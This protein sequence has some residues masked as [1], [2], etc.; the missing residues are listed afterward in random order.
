MRAWGGVL[1]FA[2]ACVLAGTAEAQLAQ[3]LGGTAADGTAYYERFEVNHGITQQSL[4]VTVDVMT[5][6]PAGMY[7]VIWDCD[8]F[9]TQGANS[10]SEL[11]FPASGTVQVTWT[12]PIRAGQHSVI[13]CITSSAGG[14]ATPFVGSISI[15]TGTI[16][17]GPSSIEVFSDPTAKAYCNSWAYAYPGIIAAA[18]YRRDIEIDFGTTAH[19]E[20]FRVQASATTGVNGIKVLDITGASPVQLGFYNGI[21]AIA[22]DNVLNTPSYSGIVKIRIEIYTSGASDIDWGLYFSS[23]ASVLGVTTPPDPP[24][25]NSDTK[26]SETCSA[27]PGSGGGVAIIAVCLLLLAVA[28][29]GRRLQG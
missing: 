19:A 22:V 5:T 27:A 14:A 25:G 20:A 9:S 24:L 26:K 23:T 18:N 28:R 11:D 2:I 29:V 15:G 8:G 7:V 6:S 4:T 12:S 3:S 1:V 10:F 16:T 17:R 21:S 13:F